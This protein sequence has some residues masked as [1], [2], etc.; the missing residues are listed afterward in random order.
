MDVIPTIRTAR[1]RDFYLAYLNSSS[2]RATRNRALQLAD[3]RCERCD[4]KRDLQVHHKTYERL[5]AE[6]DSDLEVVCANCHEHEHVEQMA[7]SDD[8]IYLKLARQ[9]LR[10]APFSELADLAEAVKTLC[11]QHKISY[12]SGRIT[13]ALE[14]VTGTGIKRREPTRVQ[15]FEADPR[16]ITRQEAHEVICRLDLAELVGRFLK[17]MPAVEKTAAEQ[18]E[19]ERRLREQIQRYGGIR[20]KRRPIMERLEE[21]FATGSR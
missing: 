3:Y 11:A 17:P 13:R 18:L 7:Q 5:G 1:S 20:P 16:Q 2:W 10:A 21:I 19:H 12:D 4:S 6:W 14:L 9:A 8:A 15:G